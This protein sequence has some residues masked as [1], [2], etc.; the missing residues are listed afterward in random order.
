MRDLVAWLARQLVER[1]AAGG[2][3]GEKTKGEKAEGGGG[4]TKSSARKAKAE[5]A[6]KAG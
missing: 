5:K 1:S 4:E 2:D 3:A 6:E